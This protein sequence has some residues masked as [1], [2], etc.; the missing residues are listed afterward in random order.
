MSWPRFRRK[1][2]SASGEQ[3]PSKT[4]EPAGPTLYE[5]WLA[6]RQ[7]LVEAPQPLGQDRE[8]MLRILE[9]LITRYRDSPVAERPARFPSQADLMVNER[10]IVVHHHLKPTEGGRVK[11]S[12]EAQQRMAALVK[13]ISS[14]GPQSDVEEA[15]EGTDK[16][17]E[18][19]IAEPSWLP[20]VRR[21]LTRA[22]RQWRERLEE[23][24]I[25]WAWDAL[26]PFVRSRPL[27]AMI[28]ERVRPEL[29]HPNPTVRLRA[30][31]ILGRIGGLDDFG[32]LS[33]LLALPPQDDEHPQE[34]AVLVRAIQRIS[35]S[36]Q[37]P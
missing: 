15:E 24:Q 29:A 31:T 16:T 26:R 1:R 12:Q 36:S 20:D 17:D 3:P 19:V 37:E 18:N 14:Y 4:S 28:A 30:M 32:L 2:S 22:V 21:D 35:Q 25:E 10:A 27:H 9:F 13:R 5:D 34:R 6:R 11:S 7:R 8:V 33:D 23:G